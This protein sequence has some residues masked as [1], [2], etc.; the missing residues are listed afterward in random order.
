MKDDPSTITA[1][2]AKAL[3][4]QVE[5]LG[6]RIAAAEAAGNAAEASHLREQLAHCK[7]K[8]A[9]FRPA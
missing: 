4:W 1:E 9:K 8:L 3:A 5:S 2:Q 6:R 7:A